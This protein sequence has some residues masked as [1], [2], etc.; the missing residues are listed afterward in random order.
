MT[1]ERLRVLV[2]PDIAAALRLAI[3]CF[4]SPAWNAVWCC[5]PM[6]AGR[7]ADLQDRTA[8]RLAPFA[9]IA[10]RELDSVRPRSVAPIAA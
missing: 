10:A 6:D 9:D 1:G 2:D 5:E 3:Y 8:G 4:A 7:I